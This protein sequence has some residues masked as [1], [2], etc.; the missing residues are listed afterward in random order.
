MPMHPMQAE[1]AT[2]YNTQLRMQVPWNVF[3]GRLGKHSSQWTL[4]GGASTSRV[5]KSDASQYVFTLIKVFLSI[6]VGMSLGS[7]SNLTFRQFGTTVGSGGCAGC[8]L[9]L[10]AVLSDRLGTS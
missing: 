2:E 7:I 10:I 5:K 6:S 4:K 3:V 1:T 8:V 9:E